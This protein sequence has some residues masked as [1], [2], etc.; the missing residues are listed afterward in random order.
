LSARRGLDYA[1]AAKR[2]DPGASVDRSFLLP[3]VRDYNRARADLAEAG[4]DLAE[5]RADPA[6]A[7]TD[8]AQPRP[9]E[10]RESCRQKSRSDS[11][12]A[13]RYEG[14]IHEGRPEWRGEVSQTANRY[15]AVRDDIC[16]SAQT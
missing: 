4:P 2:C 14:G 16:L 8:L 3:L 9:C 1:H 10:A 15:R 11:C 6:Q 12:E 5:A 13:V 7:R